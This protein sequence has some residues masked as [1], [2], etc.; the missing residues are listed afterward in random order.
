M[1]KEEFYKKKSFTKW[2]V[3]QRFTLVSAFFLLKGSPPPGN[4]DTAPGGFFFSLQCKR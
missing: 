4:M 2:Y 1:F 3:K